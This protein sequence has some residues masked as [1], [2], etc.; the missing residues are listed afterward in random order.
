MSNVKCNEYS[1]SR[2]QWL[3]SVGSPGSEIHH[4]EFTNRET[5]TKQQYQGF[6][7]RF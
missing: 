7:I 3:T 6:A 5:I 2:S 1:T 4:C